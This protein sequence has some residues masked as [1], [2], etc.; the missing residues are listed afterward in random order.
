[1][2][3]LEAGRAALGLPP[4]GV[5]GE[6]GELE[7]AHEVKVGGGYQVTMAG[8]LPAREEDV[9]GRKELGL[10]RVYPRLGALDECRRKEDEG[11]ASG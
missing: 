2:L 5:A 4:S 7:I 8:R 3:R 10:L 1:M 6:A 11:C 9:T